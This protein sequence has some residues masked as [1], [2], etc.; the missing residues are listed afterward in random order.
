[1]KPWVLAGLIL[2]AAEFLPGCSSKPPP[3]AFY[4][5]GPIRE[6]PRPAAV[7]GPTVTVDAPSWLWDSRIRY[8]LLYKAAGRLGYYRLTQWLA[9]PPE[10]LQQWLDA[11]GRTGDYLLSIELTDFEQRFLSPGEAYVVI[12]MKAAVF[13]ANYKNKWGEHNF[14]W[15]QACSAPNADG[16]VAAFREALRQA[17]ADLNQWLAQVTPA[18]RE[19]RNP[20]RADP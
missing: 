8:R 9:T 15:R 6:A 16:A 13:S 19:Q 1:M 4:D 5:F 11:N 3:R 20:A 14:Y 10:L 12:A 2:A 18:D 17:N 7:G